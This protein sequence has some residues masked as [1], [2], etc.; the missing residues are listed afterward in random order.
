M[1]SSFAQPESVSKSHV[2][3]GSHLIRFTGWAGALFL[4]VFQSFFRSVS[5]GSFGGVFFVFCFSDLLFSFGKVQFSSRMCRP[6]MLVYSLLLWI[7]FQGRG[8]SEM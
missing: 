2:L 6:P 1:L 3:S 7:D 4:D 5:R 8:A